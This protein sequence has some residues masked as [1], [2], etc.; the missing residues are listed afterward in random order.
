[1]SSIQFKIARTDSK[2]NFMITVKTI[3]LTGFCILINN[4]VVFF[5]KHTH[6]KLIKKSKT[7]N[8]STVNRKYWVTP[9]FVS[10]CCGLRTF[11][12]ERANRSIIR[13]QNSFSWSTYMYNVCWYTFRLFLYLYKLIMKMKTVS[14][15]PA[16]VG[17]KSRVYMSINCK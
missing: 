17:T 1:M 11:I 15:R 3:D 10:H 16:Y 7:K 2:Q 5:S 9:C 14:K 8:I 6:I 4:T 13:H 12:V